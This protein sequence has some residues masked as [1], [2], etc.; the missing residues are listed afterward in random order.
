MR[1]IYQIVLHH[2]RWSILNHVNQC[3][4]HGGSTNALLFTDL[5]KD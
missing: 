2:S 5:S 1:H 4:Q 3:T